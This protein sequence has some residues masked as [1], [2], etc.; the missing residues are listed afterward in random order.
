M[1]VIL[2]GTGS[3][4]KN[5]VNIITKYNIDINILAFSDSN[6]TKHDKIIYGKKIISPFKI[7]NYKYDKIIIASSFFNEIRKYL[8]NIGIHDDNIV[9]YDFNYVIKLLIIEYYNEYRLCDDYEITQLI[10]FLKQYNNTLRTFCYNFFNK[11]IDKHIEVLRD[12][13]GGLYY[14]ITGGKRMYFKRS[15]N[16]KEKVLEYYNFICAEQDDLSPHKYLSN[17]FDVD[18]NS[19]IVDIGVA[20]GNFTFSVIDKIKKAYLFESDPEWIEALELTFKEYSNKVKIINTFV[21]NINSENSITLDSYNFGE[22][23]SFIKMDVEGNER[24]VLYG[25]KNLIS[26]NKLKIAVCTYH[27]K[28][29][30]EII[31]TF[32]KNLNFKTCTSK[33]YMFFFGDKES[34]NPPYFRKGLIRARNF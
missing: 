21:S 24:L 17:D 1:N 5:I 32:L 25:S 3:M 19:V 4:C 8:I 23:V 6:I 16:T 11:Y 31:N 30:Y 28:D 34:Y 12:N 10:T 2:Y 27:K 14:V 7:K 9:K 22:N 15:L 33:G 26:C 13:K 20:E 29:D 18:D